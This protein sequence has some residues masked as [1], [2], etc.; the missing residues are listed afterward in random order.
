MGR[1]KPRASNPPDRPRAEVAR[2]P[3]EATLIT[4]LEPVRAHLDRPGDGVTLATL[5]NIAAVA[6][7]LSRLERAGE[8]AALVSFRQAWAGILGTG[9]QAAA[10]AG[11]LLAHA[12]ALDPEDTRLMV[13]AH[14]AIRRGELVAEVDAVV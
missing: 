1:W 13:R 8:S 12:R 14:A 3:L 7:N 6:W 10:I 11:A 2:A 4:L 5:A 9:E